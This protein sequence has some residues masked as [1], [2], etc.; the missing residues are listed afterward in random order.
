[1]TMELANYVITKMFCNEIIVLQ[2]Q[3]ISLSGQECKQETVNQ[4]AG[5]AL[6]IFFIVCMKH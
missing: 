3:Y 5:T 4:S 2:E 1:M 6:F